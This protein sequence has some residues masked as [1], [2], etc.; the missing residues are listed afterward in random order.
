MQKLGKYEIL[1]ELG[2]GAMGVVY[3]A[4][5][6][7]IGRLVALKTINSNLVDRPDLL[8]RFYQEAQ[9]AGKLQHPNIV[10][11]FELGQE[12]DTPFIAM[13]YIDGES[14]EK[15]IVE[16]IDL[17]LAL[18]IGYIVRVCQA[19]EF[20]HKNRVV[21]RDIKP[22]NV[23]VTSEG[24]VKVVDFGIARLVD[25]SR[26]HTNM[27]IGTPAYMAPELFRKK[28]ADERTDI[29]AV[30]V[31]FYELICYQRPFTGEGYDIIRAI[32]EDDFPL[33]SSISS[34]C[35]PELDAIIG[36]MLRK[37]SAE[38]YQ[39]MEDVLLE[40]EP[41]WNRMRSEAASALAER[42]RGLYE[43]GNLPRAQD[44][45]RRARMIDS[46]NVLAKSL[47]EKVSAELRRTE[48]QPKV[49]QHLERGRVLLQSG[50]FSE[51]QA[52]AEAAL[53]LDSR[54]EPA[55]Q[56]VSEVEAGTARAQQFDKK[57][58]LTKQRLAEGA[59][60]EA[61][62]ALRQALELDARH[63]EALELQRQIVEEQSRRDKRKQLTE[64]LNRARGLWTELKYDECLE[65][66][67]EGLQAF[68]NEP[69]LK[70]LQET[71]RQDQ[72]E[73]SKQG[74]LAEVRML[75]AQ[76]RLADARR[77]LESLEKAQPQDTS[78]KHLHEL[79]DLEEREHERNQRIQAELASLRALVSS[80]KLSEAVA[81]G[82]ALLPEFPQEY[83][84]K[85]LISYASGEIAHRQQKK[86]EQERQQQIEGLMAAQR[87][88]E[89]SDAARRAAQEFP[90]QD[91][92][93]R[94]LGD[95][96]QK[97]IAIEERKQAEREMQ[98]RVQEIQ[99]KIKRQ[100]LTGAIDLAKHSLETMGPDTD[101]TRL[102]QRAE[103]QSLERNKK[104]EEGNKQLEAAQTLME[105]QDFTGARQVLDRAMATRILQPGDAQQMLARIAA[106]EKR[107][108]DELT[109]KSGT[110]KSAK[111]GPGS[112]A[113]SKPTG[114]IA[115]PGGFGPGAPAQAKTPR[116]PTPTVA[117]PAGAFASTR[118]RQE[119]SVPVMTPPPAAP[120]ATRIVQT[121]V[122]VEEGPPV[123]AAAA[124]AKSGS[125]ALLV[126]LLIVF[127]IGIVGGGAYAAFRFLPKYLYKPSP[128][129][130]AL[131][132]EAKQLWN[133]HKLDDSLADWRKLADHAGPLHD[134]AMKR[135]N[136]LEQQQASA[137]QKYAEGMKLL[138]EEKKYPE[139]T[140]KFNEVI[141]M[142]SWK[143]D[144]AHHEFDVASKGPSSDV[145]AVP[146][147]QAFF[148]EGKRA[149][150]KKDYAAATQDFE[151]VTRA[152]G[153]SKDVSAQTA[154]LL[155]VVKDRSEQKKEFDDAMRLEKSG[156]AQQAKDLFTRVVRASNGDLDLV[157]S[158]KNQID[159]IGAIPE[160][161]PEG[162]RGNGKG[163]E[164][165]PPAD[166]SA[167]A[168]E[169]RDLIGQGRWDDAATKLSGVPATQPEFGQ[170]KAQIETGRS[171]DKYYTQMKSAFNGAN[172]S[173]NKDALLTL[174]PYF[175]TEVGKGDRHSDDARTVVT[176]IDADLR[177]AVLSSQPIGPAN[178]NNGSATNAKG[179]DPAAIKDVLNRYAAALDSGD[180]LA[181]SAVRQLSA[182]DQDKIQNILDSVKGKGYQI[183]DCQK[184]QMGRTTATITCNGVFT[185]SSDNKPQSVNFVLRRVNGQWMIVSQN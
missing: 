71:A 66:L 72:Q 68:P 169:V 116:M 85:D 61:Q 132:G 125:R 26:T 44:A 133:D 155:L 158:A 23:M 33:A 27:M 69:E 91:E 16:Q 36:R 157:A 93:R 48:I 148:D 96:E 57:M 112:P 88:S 7:F 131:A 30:G 165:K 11:V 98:R 76:Q 3:K 135:V 176:E 142:N 31:T 103:V 170:L 10:T 177:E 114:T 45:L 22:G 183:Q 19:L 24:V 13:E 109:K 2:H 75:L 42:A 122:R 51:A 152:D 175:T 41:V 58:R 141:Q 108:A 100:E 6:P 140:A 29:W 89:A 63:P 54:Y 180:L 107:R 181:L 67:N 8:E 149:F 80:G 101:V 20:A 120:P 159:Q 92:F 127:G 171:E 172:E 32:A 83:E 154:G 110:Q 164:S 136:D 99:S 4:R 38:R 128:E 50:K 59:I 123:M 64:L 168:G 124:P 12:K 130:L 167:A 49:D 162:N 5:D 146:I 79:L 111:P 119:S 113:A 151:Q 78:I 35:N 138:Y 145:S 95:A 105:K 34:E 81:K 52:E 77:A 9:S 53:N 60:L 121:Q 104:R 134:S 87:Y 18:K 56:F 153:V 90:K 185:K 25:F 174:R 129:D 15:I 65:V 94:L 161:N 115:E 39:S 37:S 17:P 84:L 46:S 143:L 106:E 97:R 139:A 62:T 126:V 74:N 40:L 55:Q 184:P 14:L 147:W 1:A 178:G 82:N 137:E 163:A 86:S 21:H 73:Q 118:S 117:D 28:K 173:R 150:D 156:H 182:K 144:E 47:L 43:R 70:S 102:L 179:N 166:Y 160:S